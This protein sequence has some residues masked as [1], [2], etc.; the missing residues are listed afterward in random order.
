MKQSLTVRKEFWQILFKLFVFSIGLKK[1]LETT[2]VEVGADQT[3]GG[4][5]YVLR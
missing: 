3:G 1:S 2:V 5:P 4:R